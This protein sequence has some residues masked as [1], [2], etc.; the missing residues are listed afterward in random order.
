MVGHE[1]IAVK[2]VQIILNPRRNPMQSSL[3]FPVDKAKGIN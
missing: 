3:S 2:S 1:F